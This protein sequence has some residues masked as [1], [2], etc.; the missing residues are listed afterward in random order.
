M[1]RALRSLLLVLV[2]LA[3]AP[4]PAHAG[5]YDVWACH[6]P[7]GTVVPAEGWAASRQGANTSAGNSCHLYVART[8]GGL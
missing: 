8:Y 5:T 4:A 7:D 2:A 6:L 1:A 3:L